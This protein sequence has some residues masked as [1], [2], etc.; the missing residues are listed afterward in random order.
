MLSNLMNNLESYL[1]KDIAE[2]WASLHGNL[3]QNSDSSEL[4]FLYHEITAK[5]SSFPWLFLA[6]MQVAQQAILQQRN[7]EVL[8]KKDQS[9]LF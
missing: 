3:Q 8:P 9:N 5:F 2:N 7:A 6:G 4:E 1:W